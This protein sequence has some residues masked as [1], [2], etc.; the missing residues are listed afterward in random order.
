MPTF[1]SIR[2]MLSSEQQAILDAVS[3]PLKDNPHLLDRKVKEEKKDE[4]E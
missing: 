1:D 3:V 4:K 2:D